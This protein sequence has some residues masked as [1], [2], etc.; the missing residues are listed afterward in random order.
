[1]KVTCHLFNVSQNKFKCLKYEACKAACFKR[2]KYEAC[3]AACFKRLKY[4]ACKAACFKCGPVCVFNCGQNE[5]PP[6]T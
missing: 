2:L 1:M 4:E 6:K 3:K 5:N